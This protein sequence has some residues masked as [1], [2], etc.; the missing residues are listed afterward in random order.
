MQA[1]TRRD[2]LDDFLLFVGEPDDDDARDVSERLLNQAIQSIW[3]RHPFK[4]F[5]VPT[6]FEVTTVAGTRSYALPDWFGRLAPRGRAVNLTTGGRLDPLDEAAL[7]EDDPAAGTTFE[8]RG[9]PEGF[10]FGGVSA[11]STEPSTSGSALEVLSD[12]AADV[13]VSVSLEGIDSNGLQARTTVTLTGTTPVALGTFKPPVVSAGKSYLEAYTPAT[14]GTS[15]RGTVSVRIVSGAT[16]LRLLP[17]EAAKQ[18]NLVT[19]YRTPGAVYTIGFPYLLAPSKLLNDAD[20]LP[21]FWE[22][23]IW[24]EMLLQWRVNTGEIPVAANLPRPEFLSLVA[25]DNAQGPA[26]HVRPYR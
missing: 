19:L 7:R 26:P 23:A 12:N 25:F 9:E 10:F 8:Q 5:R 16:L 13:D 17:D 4:A 18:F 24:E 1:A 3:L 2:F 6:L 14:E 11:L 21:A 15:S 22:A 20:P